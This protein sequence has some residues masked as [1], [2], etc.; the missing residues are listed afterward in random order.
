MRPKAPLSHT[1]PL[2]NEENDQKDVALIKTLVTHES[3]PG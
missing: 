3:N 1:M 2:C